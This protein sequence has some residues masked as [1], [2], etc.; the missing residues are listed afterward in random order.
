MTV[1][2]PEGNDGPYYTVLFFSPVKFCA[3][4]FD[5]NFMRHEA[6]L[7]MVGVINILGSFVSGGLGL[8]GLD[9]AASLSEA[10][11]VSAIGQS[12]QKLLKRIK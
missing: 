5:S 12:P 8:Q 1:L 6:T 3:R 10:S 4:C 9:P 11:M 7:T 2:L